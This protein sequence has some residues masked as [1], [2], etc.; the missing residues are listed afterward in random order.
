MHFLSIFIVLSRCKWYNDA[1]VPDGTAIIWKLNAK[2]VLN[3][4]GG[5]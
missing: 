5:A 4:D 2:G 1:V 3:H